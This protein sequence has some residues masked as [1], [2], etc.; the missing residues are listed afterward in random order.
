MSGL[1]SSP[2][3]PPVAPIAPLPRATGPSEEQLTRER[4]EAARQAETRAAAD[5]A[6]A[7]RKQTVVAGRAIAEEEQAE[8]GLLASKQRK[9]R[10]ELMG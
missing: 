5:R 9:A 1:F 6:A 8:R 2:K 7:G 3:A 4:N 10:R